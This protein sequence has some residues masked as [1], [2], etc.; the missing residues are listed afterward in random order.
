VI[1]TWKT[2]GFTYIW[3]S[4]V[5]GNIDSYTA[6][7]EN[8]LSRSRKLRL[9]FKRILERKIKT[10]VAIFEGLVQAKVMQASA[11]R[12]KRWLPMSP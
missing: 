2:C 11:E 5:S 1:L 12:F 6:D 10:A 3:C 8:I 4:K 7:L 9:H